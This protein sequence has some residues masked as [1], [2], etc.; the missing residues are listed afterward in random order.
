M[1]SEDT[2]SELVEVVPVADVYDE[3]R[4]GNSFVTD[5]EAEVWSESLTFVQTLNTRFGQDFEAEVK[6]R[7][8]AGV[9]S[10]FFCC[11]LW[12]L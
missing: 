9:W 11:F 10:V 12:R 2:N 8:E 1:S 7:F 5:L 6:A 3:D 4:V